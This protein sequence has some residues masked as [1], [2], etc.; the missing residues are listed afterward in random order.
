MAIISAVTEL[1]VNNTH[2]HT[3]MRKLLHFLRRRFLREKV[4]RVHK[5]NKI[6][7]KTASVRRT[8][9]ESRLYE[10]IVFS[11]L[12][13]SNLVTIIRFKHIYYSYI[14]LTYNIFE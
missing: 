6:N 11:L 9:G 14:L 5:N 12:N 13:I 10:K 4:Y 7:E 8:T 3:H 2:T 1:S